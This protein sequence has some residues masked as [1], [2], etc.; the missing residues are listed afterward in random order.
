MSTTPRQLPPHQPRR[1]AHASDT[2][3]ASGRHNPVRSGR[4]A[5]HNSGQCTEHGR[6]VAPICTQQPPGP[7]PDRPP[8]ERE[9]RTPAD[10]DHQFPGHACRAKSRKTLIA[11]PSTDERTQQ[12]S[13]RPPAASLLITGEPQHSFSPALRIPITNPPRSRR[14]PGPYHFQLFL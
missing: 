13:G 8:V 1:L 10:H 9:H 6:R 3:A 11:R 14:R 4:P 12:S 7:P 2:P 5:G